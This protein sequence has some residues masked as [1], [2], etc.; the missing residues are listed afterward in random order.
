ME[1]ISIIVPAYNEQN[2]IESTYNKLSAEL[3]KMPFD[4]EILVGNDGSKD[5]TLKILQRI[6]KKDKRLKPVSH[7][8]NKG[9]GY[10]LKELW[11]TAKGTYI[12]Y[13]D[14]DLSL[15]PAIIPKLVEEAKN[16]DVV[17]SSKYVGIKPE[18]LPF[19]RMLP[20]RVYYIINRILFGITVKDL[21]S[22]CVLFRKKILEGV[23]VKANRFDV[24]VELFAK[25]FRKHA[26]IKEI[27]VPYK[28]RRE[29]GK[30]SV[31]EDGPKTL[32]NTLKIW[33]RLTTKG[34]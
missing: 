33:W 14:A 5:N 34:D 30:F 10:T 17:V 13:C 20:S 32:A 15:T 2:I 26:R 18:D 21:G 8:P 12:I 16:A 3:K 6:A 24:H 19:T 28:H 23:N 25:L 7:Y 22:G 4:Y 11:N 31:L 9:L 27:A 29:E 1:R